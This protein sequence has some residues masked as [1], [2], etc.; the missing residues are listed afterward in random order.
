MPTGYTA[1][2]IDGKTETFQDFA[3]LVNQYITDKTKSLW[4]PEKRK[5]DSIMMWIDES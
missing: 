3:K 1:G 4:I 2:I 5:N